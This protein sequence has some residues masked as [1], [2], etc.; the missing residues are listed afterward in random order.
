MLNSPSCLNPITFDQ[1]DLPSRSFCICIEF[2]LVFAL[3][4]CAFP[5]RWF[6]NPSHFLPR[7]FGTLNVEAPDLW[8][9]LTPSS[10]TH[11]QPCFARQDNSQYSSP[12]SSPS[13]LADISQHRQQRPIFCSF[14]LLVY[15]LQAQI[16]RWW[17]QNR[18]ISGMPS[19][20]I[21]DDDANTGKINVIQYKCKTVV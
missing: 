4:I 12:S 13:T 5:Q 16:I 15:F 6:S 3:H 1:C 2:L 14:V 20:A 18:Q 19:T 11:L 21:I 7:F 10:P 17:I 9:M 8:Y